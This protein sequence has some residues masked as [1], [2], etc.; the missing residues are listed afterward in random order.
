MEQKDIEFFKDEVTKMRKG[1]GGGFTL[2]LIALAL[3]LIFK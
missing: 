2:V 3:I 1:I